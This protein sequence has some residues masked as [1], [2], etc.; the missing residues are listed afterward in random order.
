MRVSR[1][2]PCYQQGMG[3]VM[4]ST[5]PASKPR[6]VG[7]MDEKPQEDDYFVDRVVGIAL[8]SMLVLGC[9]F[10]LIAIIRSGDPAAWLLLLMF[11]PIAY[12]VAWMLLDK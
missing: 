12:L 11:P 4:L 3:D 2:V 7:I 6:G 8:A 5:R 9:V 1:T 10:A